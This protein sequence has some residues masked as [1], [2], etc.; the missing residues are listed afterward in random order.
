M[1]EKIK[2]L[3]TLT[4]FNKLLEDD[5]VKAL[6][7]TVSDKS[8]EEYSRFVSHIYNEGGDFSEYLLNLAKNDD[9]IFLRSNKMRESIPVCI[10][11]SILRELKILQE[12]AAITSLEL[13]EYLQHNELSDYDNSELDFVKEYME[14]IKNLPR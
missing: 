9:N 6:I 10:S 8:Y 1:E 3:K 14:S 12:I 7:G 5:A 4:V 2:K 11:L 13:K